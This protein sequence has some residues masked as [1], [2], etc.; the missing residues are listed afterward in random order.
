MKKEQY[1]SDFSQPGAIE[2]D[3]GKGFNLKELYQKGLRV[4]EGFILQT[5]F[6]RDH[7]P[8]PPDFDY[9]DDALLEE[10]C[11]LQHQRVL[12]IS[13]PLEFLT[14]LST[15]L[16]PF[17]AAARF[18]VRS[19]SSFEDLAGAAFAGQHDTYLNIAPEDVATYIR[20]CLASLWQRHA[21]LYRRHHR[22]EQQ[23][24]S[25]AVVIQRMIRGRVAGVAF[26]IDPV[27]GNLC[28]ALVEAN[29]GIGESVVGGEAKTD[30]WVVHAKTNEIVERRITEKE[31]KDVAVERGIE[32]VPL[33]GADRTIPC[34]NDEQI[35]VIVRQSQILL[36]LYGAPQDMEWVIDGDELYIVQCRPQTTIPPRLTRDESAERFPDPL[37]PLTWS[38]VQDAFNHSLEYSLQLMNLHLPTRPWFELVDHYVYGNQNAVELLALHRPIKATNF[39]EL[40][41]EVPAL[42]ERYRWVLDLPQRWMRDLDTYLLRIGKLDAKNLDVLDCEDFHQHFNELL[43]L[44]KEYFQ[45]NIAISMTQAFLTHTLFGVVKLLCQNE[46]T[47]HDLFK[48]II[49][50]PETKT[51]Q[52]NRELY[53]LAVLVRRT[54][55]LAE[56]LAGPGSQKLEKIIEFPEFFERFQSFIRDFG[57]REIHFDYYH[58]TWA[59]A[60][61]VV[62]DLI[63]LTAGAADQPSPRAK[64][65]ELRQTQQQATRRL[66]EA[67]PVELH[68]FLQELIRLTLNFTFLDDLEHFQT[69]RLN[70]LARRAAGV[71]GRRLKSPALAD[72]YDLF[73]LTR[74]EVQTISDFTL[75]DTL[76]TM[77][78]ERKQAFLAAQRQPPVWDLVDPVHDMVEDADTLRGVPGSP[79]QCQGEVYLVHGPQDFS[80]VPDGAILVARTTNPAWTPLFY[81]AKGIVTESGGP[82][83]H[84]AVTARELGIPAVMSIRGCM[85]ILQN[86]SRIQ[87]NG[88]QGTVTR[89]A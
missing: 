78:G 1:F 31:F 70:L 72:P 89:I 24:A 20:K 26:S 52:I 45:P 8:S 11:R 17:G 2:R 68:F 14:Q 58:P 53:E 77:I 69:T 75:T 61:E 37:T 63:A 46:S 54:P 36:H 76:G 87:V 27:S 9:D 41:E 30:S 86:G 56:L 25:M 3:G 34:L 38:Y 7:Y 43:E 19:S 4:P 80:G 62:L 57:H 48:Q 55:A 40:L 23:D 82:L 83:S 44:A 12:D 39:Q 50:V 65:R 88:R 81:K 16:G 79:G 13:L 33:V 67:T 47:A 51:G 49:A 10:Q 71:F 6:Y 32:R 85:T 21:V 5:Q 42:H 28:H 73:F 66:F 84:G 29:W 18:A 35:K 15:L 74:Q 59:E 64:E 60:P 22:F